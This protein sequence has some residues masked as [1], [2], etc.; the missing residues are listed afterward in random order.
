MNYA[1][2]LMRYDV[3]VLA[4]PI[5]Q[6][7]D[8]GNVR[9]DRPDL[10]SRFDLFLKQK[11]AYE[12]AFDSENTPVCLSIDY[13]WP[14]IPRVAY[15]EAIYIETIPAFGMNCRFRFLVLN[16]VSSILERHCGRHFLPGV[17]RQ[18]VLQPDRSVNWFLLIYLFI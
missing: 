4:G 13:T 5:I 1:L 2:E 16:T 6:F 7:I 3:E 15:A 9:L 8:F 17:F 11:T 14:V 12:V 18:P 10:F